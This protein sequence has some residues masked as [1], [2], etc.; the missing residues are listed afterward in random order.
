[1]KPHPVSSP[2][3]Y[4]CGGKLLTVY[5]IMG[6]AR[7]H[8]F[9]GKEVTMKSRLLRGISEPKEL[10]KNVSPQHAEASAIHEVKKAESRKEC[11]ELLAA[12]DARKRELTP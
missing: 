2:K 4:L 9:T 12:I 3:R 5:Q 11:A 1:V 7:L 8:G 6:L 10:F